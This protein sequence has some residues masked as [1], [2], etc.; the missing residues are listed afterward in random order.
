MR[1]EN[2]TIVLKAPASSPSAYRHPS[3]KRPDRRIPENPLLYMYLT[4]LNILH[5][6]EGLRA[7]CANTGNSRID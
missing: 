6:S 4:R 2:Q 5:K 3:L 1:L 7:L